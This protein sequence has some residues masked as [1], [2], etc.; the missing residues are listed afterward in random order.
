[1]TLSIKKRLAAYSYEVEILG[2][3]VEI[4]EYEVERL[5][6]TLENTVSGFRKYGLI[7]IPLWLKIGSISKRKGLDEKSVG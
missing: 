2:Y 4:L 5:G 3:E 7:P 1:M 6:L